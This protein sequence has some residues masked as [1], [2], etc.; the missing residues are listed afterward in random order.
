MNIAY[1]DI[2]TTD[3]KPEIGRIICAAVLTLPEG[4]MTVMSLDEYVADGR[5]KNFSDDR[6]LCIDLRNLLEKHNITAGWYTKGFDIPFL[7][8]RL[9]ANKQR[10][11]RKQ[12]HLDGIW[13]AK[14][15]R[16]VKALNSSLA[17]TARL[18]GI[19]EKKQVVDPETWADARHG[20][21]KAMKIVRE[22]C[23]SDVVLT[24]NVIEKLIN[25]GLV[26]NIRSYP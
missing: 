1:W 14:G 19:R 8:S 13:Y 20:D 24:R 15:W 26:A 18:L 12:L 11:L 21:P 5:A 2:E 3:L 4:K 23:A 7:N 9:I 10:L 16:G 17:S 22:R 6:R 25:A